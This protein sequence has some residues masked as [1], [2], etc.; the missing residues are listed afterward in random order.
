M[1][2]LILAILSLCICGSL[3]AGCSQT[4]SMSDSAVSAPTSSN[5]TET[6]GVL[7]KSYD[8]LMTLGTETSS[9]YSMGVQIGEYFN[10]IAPD[11]RCTVKTG[12]ASS[13]IE[14]VNA[15]QTVIAHTQSDLLY[16]A[17]NGI[18]NF[19]EKKDS[20]YGVCTIME[21]MFH[22]AVSPDVPVDSLDQLIEQKYPLKIS[23]GT[24]GSGIESLFRKIL[25]T[26]GVTYD[27]IKFWGGKIEFLGMSDASDAFKDG[28]LNAVTILAGV[29]YSGITEVATSSELKFLDV[30]Q[31]V[32]DQLLTQGYLSKTIP[33]GSYKGQ[34]RDIS[35]VGVSI[36]IIASKNAN[37]AVIYELTKYLNS[38][39]GITAMSAV[40]SGFADYMKGPKTGVAGMDI[41]LHPGA[42]RYYKEAGVA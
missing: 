29:P 33:A 6:P 42:E 37:E 14:L 10:S 41:P 19:N 8:L 25:S 7:P 1:K 30:P 2:K 31:K 27:D 3:M 39:E 32:K 12:A 22:L 4:V 40:N 16:E 26:Y 23:V 21:S 5:Q 17:A 24:Q 20:V 38:E 15:G 9:T 35:T 36:S 18:G 13:N 11:I 34:D 28:Q